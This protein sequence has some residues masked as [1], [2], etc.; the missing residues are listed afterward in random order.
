VR[1]IR[2]AIPP[3]IFFTIAAAIAT[4][5]DARRLGSML[6]LILV[7]YL[8]TSAVAA[9]VGIAAGLALSPGAGVGLKVPEGYKPPTPPSGVDVLLSFFQV[10]FG[11][12]LTVGG[13]MTMII[14]SILVG[15]ASVFMGGSGRR[16]AELLS[17]GSE[18]M[19]SLVRVVMYYA[20]VAVFAYAAWLMIAYGPTLLG[21][22]AKFLAAQY[23][24]TIMYFLVMYSLL[25]TAGGVN[26][27]TY[28]RAQLTPF[29]IAFTTRS[30]AVALPANFEAAKRMGVPR[31]IYSITLPI[32]ATVNMDGTAIYQAL[33]AVF[34]AQLFGIALTPYHLTLLVL[35]AVIGSVATAAVPGGGT[36]MLAYVLSVLGLPLEGVGIMLAIDPIADALRTAVNI[37]GDNAATALIAKLVGYRLKQ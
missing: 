1:V 22:Y 35:A 18:L 36:I 14:F 37:S 21:A 13:S 28:F 20:P 9:S 26:P 24:F 4:I 3:L 27:L 30:S 33:S 17:T 10:E 31:E 29:I 12:L 7:I 16:V 11:N 15:V 34:I 5:A 23:S 25:V 19:V 32:G 2:V 8:G 6:I